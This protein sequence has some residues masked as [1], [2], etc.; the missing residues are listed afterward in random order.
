MTPRS[1]SAAGAPPVARAC[2]A[3]PAVARAVEAVLNRDDLTTQQKREIADT[4]ST[5][6]LSFEVET[7]VRLNDR[8]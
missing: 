8:E 1:G 4:C 5:R 3:V 7:E 6:G 2:D